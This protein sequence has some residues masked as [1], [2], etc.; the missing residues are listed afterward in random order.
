MFAPLPFCYTNTKDKKN[1]TRSVPK[2]GGEPSGGREGVVGR[3]ESG[4]WTFPIAASARPSPPILRLYLFAK[5]KLQLFP[6][7]SL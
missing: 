6:P 1:C 4:K 3:A 5:V 2:R 7:S